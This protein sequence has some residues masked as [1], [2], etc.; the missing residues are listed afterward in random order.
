VKVRAGT[1]LVFKVLKV[2]DCQ[3]PSWPRQTQ[4]CVQ[5]GCRKFHRLD[6]RDIL[7]IDS[8][9]C[10]QEATLSKCQNRYN[11]SIQRYTLSS[12]KNSSVLLIIF[13]RYEPRFK[14]AINLAEEF[15]SNFNI[16]HS[17]KRWTTEY[18]NLQLHSQSSTLEPL[19]SSHFCQRE[20]TFLVKLWFLCHSPN[21]K[22]L[23][24]CL[25]WPWPSA[26]PQVT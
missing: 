21:S 23:Q 20:G 6:S 22:P 11:H 4:V 3:L 16:F 5:L 1:V 9:M 13:L 12:C 18:L 25:H 10:R 15:S 2:V 8:S 17:Q 14:L 26:Y 19:D 24:L 7:K